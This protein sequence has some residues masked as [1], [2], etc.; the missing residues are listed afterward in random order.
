M[1]LAVHSTSNRIKSGQFHLSSYSKSVIVLK[2]WNYISKCQVAKS[3]VLFNADS[4]PRSFKCRCSVS[5]IITHSQ[6]NYNARGTCCIIVHARSE[7]LF[8]ELTGNFSYQTS[9]PV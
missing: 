4:K 8:Q 9:F 5:N 2:K 1:K 6:T 7:N 3:E